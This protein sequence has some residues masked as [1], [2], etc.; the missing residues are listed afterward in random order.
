MDRKFLGALTL[1]AVMTGG[2]SNRDIAS[3]RQNTVTAMASLAEAPAPA[4]PTLESQIS[5][6]G[7]LQ[8]VSQPEPQKGDRKLIRNGEMTIEVKSVEAAL[9]SLVEMVRSIGGQST[10]QLERQNEYGARTASVTWLV[11][12]E[13][14][15]AAIAAV[16]ALGEPQLLSFKTEDVTTSYFDVTVRISTQKQLE[17]QLVALL[18]RASNR[19]SD[20]LEIEREVARVREEID[21]L[22]GRIRLWDSQLAMS[23][24]L[25][26]LT[27]PAPIAAS[28]GGPLATLIASF[29]VAGEN[30]VLTVAG[31][32][33]MSGSALPVMLLLAGPAWLAGRAWR[34]T[35]AAGAPAAQWRDHP[36]SPGTE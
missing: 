17:Q 35:R 19:L 18:R 27:E 9:T 29:G 10:N 21:R 30:F 24:V 26:T 6:A 22:E 31:L 36:F 28:T 32:V 14:L 23:S 25:I 20:L 16:R 34:R 2:C 13:R 3:T 5:D 8:T 1:A 7:R 33:A 15:D 4:P 12:A 11:P